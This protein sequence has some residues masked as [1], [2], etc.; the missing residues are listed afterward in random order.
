MNR[1]TWG[2]EYWPVFLVVVSSLFLGPEAFAFFTNHENTLSDFAWYELGV[3]GTY[4][5]H[6]WAW[7]FSLIA[8][9]VFLAVLI[10]HIWFKVPS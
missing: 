8:V 9:V 10:G 1:P 3:S 5:S 6:S 2:L 7:W 4:G